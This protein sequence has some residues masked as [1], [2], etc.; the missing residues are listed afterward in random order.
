MTPLRRF[1]T[2]ALP[3]CTACLLLSVWMVFHSLTGVRLAGCAAG[4]SCDEV[5]GSP[6]AYV[7]GGVPVSLP[8]A[9]LYA[10]LL[11]CLLF[12]GGS[13]PEDRSLDRFLWRL[14]PLLGGCIVGAA[15]WFAYLQAGVLHA[16][17]KY[18]TALHLLGCILAV[19]FCLR[20]R[21]EGGHPLPWFAAGLL[22]AALFAFVQART[23]PDAVYDSGRTDADLPVFD[24]GDVPVL[25]GGEEEAQVTLTLLFDFQCTHCRRLHRILPE[26]LERTQGRYRILLCP[27]PLSSACN[28]YIP[29]SG[30]DRF[31]GS[32]ALTRL[33]LAVWYARP[34]AWAAYWDF[35]LGAGDDRAR[36]DLAEAERRAR[37]ILGDG[38]GQALQDPRIKAYLDKVYEL[39]G[40]TSSSEKSGV[41]R[42]IAGQRW[43]VPETDSAEEL[44]ALAASL[45]TN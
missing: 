9:V 20:A 32:C 35:L 15:L 27:L 10:L 30:I 1:K 25:T 11:L 22:A 26:F 36:T 45:V 40:R 37:E 17:C 3:L 5:M 12:L 43:L 8:A 29:A 34:D 39:F 42:L 28:P 6:W 44:S 14:M 18:C 4:G 13:R 21:R 2:W 16:F 23:R 33:S 7:L 19:S 38:Y 24:A 31:S 41:P